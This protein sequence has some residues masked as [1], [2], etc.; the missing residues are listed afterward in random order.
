MKKFMKEYSKAVLVVFLMV[1]GIVVLCYEA[2]VFLAMFDAAVTQPDTTIPALAF[3]SGF[4]SLIGGFVKSFLEKNSLNKNNL[5]VDDKGDVTQIGK[6]DE[7]GI[8]FK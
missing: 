7:K 2:Q 1:C 3:T 5:K 4:G 8:G 6:C